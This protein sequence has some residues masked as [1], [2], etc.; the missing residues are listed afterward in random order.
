MKREVGIIPV[1]LSIQEQLKFKLVESLF[2][3]PQVGIN[4]GK[5][6][7]LLDF[8]CFFLGQLDKQFG[9]L[10]K[11]NKFAVWLQYSPKLICFFY[12]LASPGL[13]I[14]EVGS[15][16]LPIQ[17]SQR[18]FTVFDVKDNLAFQSCVR[19]AYLIVF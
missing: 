16:C 2:G 19:S 18:L 6:L 11:R 15:R 12:G 5:D 4:F 8:V 9:V 7:P 13:G 1:E 3:V 17:F 14:P 10:K